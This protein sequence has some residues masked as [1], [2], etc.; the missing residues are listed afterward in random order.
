MKPLPGRAFMGFE[1]EHIAGEIEEELRFHVELLT[2][3]HLRQDLSLAEAKEAA[4]QRFGSVEQIR[5]Q[6]VEISQRS[7]PVIRALKSLLVSCFL[8]GVLVRVSSTEMHVARVGDILIFVAV[9]GRLLL[10]LRSMN[11][12]SFRASAETASPLMLNDK[13]YTVSAYDHRKLTPVE[14]IISDK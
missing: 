1:R 9:L 12:T 10:Y 2:E 5:N 6:C 8:L 4:L 11:P 7:R 3:E 13:S 14:R